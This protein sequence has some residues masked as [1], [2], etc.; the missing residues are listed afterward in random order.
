MS[1]TGMRIGAPS[2]LA[3]RVTCGRPPRIRLMSVL[4]PPM[5]NVMISAKPES[6][7]TCALATTPP[8]GPDKTVC[9]G[10][11]RAVATVINPPEASMT[12]T[13][14]SDARPSPSAGSARSSVSEAR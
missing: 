2:R 8:A 11:S 10:F 14:T 4:V 7:A 5:S 9:T 13:G 6:W 1:M 12:M 3:S